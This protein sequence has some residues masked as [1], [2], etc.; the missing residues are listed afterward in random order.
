MSRRRPSR[1]GKVEDDPVPMAVSDD[2][3]DGGDADL[4]KVVVVNPFFAEKHLG[5]RATHP[6]GTLDTKAQLTSL[7][8]LG[9]PTR[10]KREPRPLDPP[11]VVLRRP[12]VDPKTCGCLPSKCGPCHPGGMPPSSDLGSR[13]GTVSSWGDDSEAYGYGPS[14]CGP[15]GVDVTN[16]CVPN[17]FRSRRRGGDDDD[18]LSDDDVDPASAKILKEQR[19]TR[20]PA[21]EPGAPREPPPP[22]CL[23]G[24][25]EEEEWSE[26]EKGRRR[27][28]RKKAGCLAGCAGKEDPVTGKR[29]PGF[30][31]SLVDFVD[32][33]VDDETGRRRGG[34]LGACLGNE[35]PI[36]VGKRRGG[37]FGEGCLF[38]FV[39]ADADGVVRR[40]GGCLT[41]VL[42]G[43][44]DPEDASVPPRRRGG[45]L[46]LCLGDPDPETNAR[47][48]GVLGACLGDEDPDRPG[49]R[50]RRDQPGFLL[51]AVLN[52]GD[53]GTPRR[54]GGVVGA[55][56]GDEDK[57]TGAR[58]GG[59][60]AAC[61]GD[62]DPE[63]GRRQSGCLSGCLF[64]DDDNEQKKGCLAGCDEDSDWG[65]GSSED[66]LDRDRDPSRRARPERTCLAECLRALCGSSEAS[67]RRRRRRRRR[68]REAR[69][70]AAG[71]KQ[72]GADFSDDDDARSRDH[73]LRSDTSEMSELEFRDDTDWAATAW[74]RK[75]PGYLGVRAVVLRTHKP[76]PRVIVDFLRPSM[77]LF[78]LLGAFF[79][80][81][82][83]R[84]SHR[85]WSPRVTRIPRTSKVWYSPIKEKE[86]KVVKE[87][88]EQTLPFLPD[89]GRELLA[90]TLGLLFLEK[91][92]ELAFTKNKTSAKSFGRKRDKRNEDFS[93][94]ELPESIVGKTNDK[95]EEVFWLCALF[96]QFA[97][98]ARGDVKRV[99][100]R[101]GAVIRMRWRAERRRRLNEETWS[102]VVPPKVPNEDANASEA[103]VSNEDDASVT[104]VKPDG[105]GKGEGW[106][107]PSVALPTFAL[108]SLPNLPALAD[109]EVEWRSQTNPDNDSNVK[110]DPSVEKAL[111][112]KMRRHRMTNKNQRLYWPGAEMLEIKEGAAKIAK[113]VDDVYRGDD[114]ADETIGLGVSRIR[115]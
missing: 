57:K 77:T 32:G 47:R 64:G 87:L 58:K 22:G 89:A 78:S 23:S 79:A 93:E 25:L 18:W 107:W 7:W 27:R 6:D 106:T 112:A 75:P 38:G 65:T 110:F 88:A 55:C 42:Y 4:R 98:A 68:A 115:R 16:A 31:S 49:E 17:A 33:A 52:D 41:N 70:A 39:D 91:A 48:G 100:A 95:G 54:R 19:E 2:E 102:D 109:V 104:K 71:E 37:C 9:D 44:E 113:P 46:G 13:R 63:T 92:A 94:N 8:V 85:L 80:P 105:D 66:E 40:R 5:P 59:C 51:G 99:R 11:G 81:A 67:R 43:A 103:E 34:V 10:P 101:R 111:R 69:I 62:E 82:L 86:E 53:G 26:D 35:D 96:P 28:R 21:P 36:G 84:V 76:P 108:P 29:E 90:A 97:R 72:A 50:G 3:D 83:W 74:E 60:L 20:R 45:V 1:D 73:D 114:D 30:V 24:C 61:V 56:L 12:H 15:G 14:L